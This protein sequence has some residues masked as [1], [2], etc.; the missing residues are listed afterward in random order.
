VDVIVRDFGKYVYDNAETIAAA[1]H[2]ETGV[3]VYEDKVAK[4]KLCPV[5]AEA[6]TPSRR[7]WTTST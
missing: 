2:K 3:T 1:A 5:V 4:E 6:T 7:T